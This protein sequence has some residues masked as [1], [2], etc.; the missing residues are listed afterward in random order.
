[1]TVTDYSADG[2]ERWRTLGGGVERLPDVAGVR[3]TDAL[4]PAE[5]FAAARAGAVRVR[6]T[7]TTRSAEPIEIVR[8]VGNPFAGPFVTRV[9]QAGDDLSVRRVGP[10]SRFA[11]AVAS[12]QRNAAVRDDR[13]TL[14]RMLVDAGRLAAPPA[15]ATGRFVVSRPLVGLSVGDRL[16][17]ASADPAQPWS[18]RAGR[19]ITRIE[20]RWGEPPATTITIDGGAD[21]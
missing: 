15:G 1:L 13:P 9:I 20:H 7:A 5:F 14:E 8:W 19:V 16:I 10:S 2:G 4:L 6:V 18:R 17:D 11:A 12:G 3:L 21:R